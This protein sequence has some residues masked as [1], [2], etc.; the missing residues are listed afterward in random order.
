MA[1]P[2]PVQSS[3]RDLATINPNEWEFRE[4]SLEIEVLQQRTSTINS[5]ATIE[6]N[7]GKH[8]H[9]AT[10]SQI[11]HNLPSEGNMCAASGEEDYIS[12]DRIRPGSRAES[13]ICSICTEEV[14]ESQDVRVLLYKQ[15]Y[16]R[17]CTDPW[18]L[19]FGGNCPLW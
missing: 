4:V 6:N 15:I 1:L 16:R 3:W 13:P 7:L 9:V 12:D 18:L 8:S 5:Q 14:C 10:T 2:L 11:L 19:H 17:N